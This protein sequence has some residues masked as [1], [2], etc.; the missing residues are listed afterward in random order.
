MHASDWIWAWWAWRHGGVE[1][2]RDWAYT[3]GGRDARAASTGG[4]LGAHADATGAAPGGPQLAW[5]TAIRGPAMQAS[6]L[7]RLQRVDTARP[8]RHGRPGRQWCPAHQRPPPPPLE[9]S[10]TGQPSL[11]KAGQ[12]RTDRAA[13]R[14]TACPAR[15]HALCR[16][17]PYL[18]WLLLAL[19][20]RPCSSSICRPA[21]RAAAAEAAP[22]TT[23]LGWGAPPCRRESSRPLPVASASRIAQGAALLGRA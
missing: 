22:P 20:C 7:T 21:C 6:K 17:V 14:R 18:M 3:G 10:G 23:E 15:P 9:W 2:A 12:G 13:T 4:T 19:S 11:R 16:A 8:P 1:G 5:R